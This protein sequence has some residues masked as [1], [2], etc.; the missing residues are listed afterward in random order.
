MALKLVTAL[1]I[2]IFV[3]LI[4]FV[5]MK[6]SSSRNYNLPRVKNV[7][8][9]KLP[10]L[11]N[12]HCPMGQKCSRGFCSETFMAPLMQSTDMSSCTSKECNGINAPCA[13][14]STPCEEG[15]FCQNNKCVSIS[16]PNQ[17]EAYS[18]IGM[19]LP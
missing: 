18:Q 3:S 15:T 2:V 8:V 5:V 14:S 1:A 4:V 10:C 13:R 12:K 19:I 9:A 7:E 11:A 16:A 6:L 17:G